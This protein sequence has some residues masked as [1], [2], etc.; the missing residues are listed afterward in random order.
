[1]YN[2]SFFYEWFQSRGTVIGSHTN[3]AHC[4][5]PSNTLLSSL[6]LATILQPLQINPPLNPQN[7]RAQSLQ[8]SNTSKR[9]SRWG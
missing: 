5:T 4:P 8:T 9:K 6:T 7:L 2:S 3:G 1:M